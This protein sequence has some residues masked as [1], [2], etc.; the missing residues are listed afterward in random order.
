M[1]L[2]LVTG[3]YPGQFYSP[4]LIE[5]FFWRL[6]SYLRRALP[7]L[8][9]PYQTRW[10][11]ESLLLLSVLAFGPLPTFRVKECSV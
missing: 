4:R 11:E 2:P 8:L 9:P 3:G 5:V 1:P 10:M 7:R 6:G